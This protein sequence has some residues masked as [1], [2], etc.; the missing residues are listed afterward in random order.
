MLR[1]DTRFDW[2]TFGADLESKVSEFVEDSRIG[3]YG[4]AVGLS[5]YHTWLLVNQRDGC[6]ITMEEVDKGPTAIAIREADPD[7]IHRGHELW[8]TRLRD[9]CES[10]HPRR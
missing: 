8:L 1:P 10:A 3:W 7:T 5:A 4:D 6:Y 2:Q 9:L